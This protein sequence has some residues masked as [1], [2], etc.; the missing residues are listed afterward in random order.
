MQKKQGGSIGIVM[1][2]L[3]YEPVSNS[4]EDKLAVER[5]QSFYM[6]W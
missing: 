2:A 6:N 4:L 5:G 3:W 1:N